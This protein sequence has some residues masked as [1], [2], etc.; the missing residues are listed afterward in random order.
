MFASLLVAAAKS[1]LFYTLAKV[2]YPRY[3]NLFSQPFE[4]NKYLEINVGPY[5]VVLA[6]GAL[7]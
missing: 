2:A 7:V 3:W 6:I 4:K 5:K 1:L